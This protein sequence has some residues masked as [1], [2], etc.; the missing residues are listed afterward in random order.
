MLLGATH[1]DPTI[2]DH[3]RIALSVY[4]LAA[5]L[6]FAALA[7]ARRADDALRPSLRFRASHLLPG[8]IAFLLAYP[9]VWLVGWAGRWALVA[10][11]LADTDP[12]AH[13]TLELLTSQTGPADPW[14][15]AVV[16]GAVIGAPLLEE[17][18]FRGLL[19]PAVHSI[20]RSPWIGILIPA[21]LFTLLHIPSSPDAGGAAISGVPTIAALAVALGLARA[22][23]G[24]LAVPLVMHV[25]FNALNVAMAFAVSQG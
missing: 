23:T 3:G 12:I 19:Q 15:W 25:A 6:C 16:S 14:W 1:S 18:V 13:A 24:S 2:A 8:L 10:A 9:V 22:R 17:V 21:A 5:A 11:G 4:G 20:T 7:I